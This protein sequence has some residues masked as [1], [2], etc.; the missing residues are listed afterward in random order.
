MLMVDAVGVEWNYEAINGF[1]TIQTKTGKRRHMSVFITLE[2][3]DITEI[4][5]A[6]V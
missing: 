4:G 2:S 5:R 6:H 3:G 1:Q